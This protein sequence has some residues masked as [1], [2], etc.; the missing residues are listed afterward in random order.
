MGVIQGTFGVIQGTFGMIQGIFG[1]IKM[2]ALIHRHQILF[3]EGP[4]RGFDRMGKEGGWAL[5]LN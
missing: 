3:G 1:V 2:F 5:L 4:F